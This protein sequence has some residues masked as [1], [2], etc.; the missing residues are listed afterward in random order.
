MSTVHTQGMAYDELN[1]Y[2][3]QAREGSVAHPYE[4]NQLWLKHVTALQALIAQHGLDAGRV[5]EV[6]CGRGELQDIAGDYTGLDLDFGRSKY[7]GKPFVCSSAT[8]MPFDDDTFDAAWSIWVLEHIPDPN[9]ML[10][11]MRRVVKPGGIIFL[12][13]AYSVASWISQGLHKRPFRELSWKQRLIKLTI[14]V[15]ASAIYKIVSRLLLRCLQLAGYLRRRQP[16]AVKF[17]PLTP[18]FEIYWDYDA[19]ACASIDAYSV[20]LYFLS[21]AD[22]PLYPAGPFRS[23]LQKSQPQAFIVRK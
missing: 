11:E 13:V 7:V 2:L 8:R 16:T 12:C 21:R 6:G 3:E 14:P 18:N 22:T 5:L 20:A 19:D 23:L 9:L 1:A 4:D 17:A 15:R 10:Q